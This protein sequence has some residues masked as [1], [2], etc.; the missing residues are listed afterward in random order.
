MHIYINKYITTKWIITTKV[1]SVDTS[2]AEIQKAR[3]DSRA[4][5]TK[6][7][8]DL[9]REDGICSAYTKSIQNTVRVMKAIEAGPGDFQSAMENFEEIEKKQI[10]SDWQK[11]QPLS[12]LEADGHKLIARVENQE[13]LQ[14]VKQDLK[15]LVHPFD[16]LM[17]S[18]ASTV[19]EFKAGVMAFKR[20]HEKANKVF[21]TQQREGQSGSAKAKAKSKGKGK[22]KGIKGSSGKDGMPGNAPAPV[23]AIFTHSFGSDRDVVSFTEAAWETA[24]N[25]STL[26]L[27]EPFV[28]RQVAW[29][30]AILEKSEMRAKIDYFENSFKSQIKV[31]VGARGQSFLMANELAEHL[32]AVVPTSEQ[33]RKAVRVL[34]PGVDSKFSEK[35]VAYGES[36]RQKLSGVSIFGLATGRMQAG[37]IV[38]EYGEIGGIRMSFQGPACAY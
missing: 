36:M 2:L 35:V 38:L 22:G 33:V 15:V 30:K 10:C 16:Q 7:G 29:G 3:D 25:E 23:P 19:R 1:L 21:E 8:I 5:C 37:H 6:L 14:Q 24:K 28:V 27:G 20:N 31:D 11:L 9:T 4:T 34:N 17:S 32:L 26:N 13:T 12:G 18:L